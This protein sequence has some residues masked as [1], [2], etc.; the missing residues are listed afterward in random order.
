MLK[1]IVMFIY[2]VVVDFWARIFGKKIF[3]EFGFTLY[4]G[5]QGA[6]KTMGMV[7]YLENIREQYPECMIITN[8]GYIHETQPMKTWEDIIQIRNGVKGV[9][10]AIDELQNEYSSNA[11]KD[12][13]E[14]ILSQITQQRKQRIKIIGT[15]QVFTRVVK[16][17]REQCF[18]VVEC[19][20]W[21]GRWTHLHAFDAVDY[22][23][24]FGEPNLKNA[25]P[26]VW[27]QSFIQTNQMRELYNSYDVIEK[28][29]S[30]TYQSAEQK[31]LRNI[32]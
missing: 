13:P 5:R 3:N 27:K 26:R 1:K 17:I 20:T 24:T 31:K 15:S 6:G 8:F 12:F 32:I 10:F 21:L 18:E 11:W 29:A 19:K 30:T 7:W 4:C 25:L 28:L 2:Y 14:E 22:N 9:V 16:Q 23:S